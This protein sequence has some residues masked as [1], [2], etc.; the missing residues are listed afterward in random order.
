MCWWVKGIRDSVRWWTETQ[1][2]DIKWIFKKSGDET[3]AWTVRTT[4]KLIWNHYGISCS[5]QAVIT[6]YAQII[7]WLVQE[8]RN[9]SLE[10]RMKA[11]G[12]I[13]SCSLL[14]FYWLSYLLLNK[15]KF[16]SGSN[17]SWVKACCS[18]LVPEFPRA[19]ISLST[20]LHLISW[21]SSL[22][23]QQHCAFMN[24]ELWETRAQVNE[25]RLLSCDRCTV[26]LCHGDR[27]QWCVEIQEWYEIMLKFFAIIFL[28]H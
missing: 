9:E 4:G 12:D 8:R 22:E 16:L 18:S 19:L 28:I 3:Y 2:L 17:A 13:T 15:I 5:R 20:F 14:N 21:S 6:S 10:R 23:S 1:D 24:Q 26:G 27:N 11:Y 7:R 25:Q